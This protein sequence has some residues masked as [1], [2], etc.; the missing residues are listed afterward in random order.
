MG[1]TLE[2]HSCRAFTHSLH[3]VSLGLTAV[4]HTSFQMHPASTVPSAPTH[5]HCD[6]CSP[7]GARRGFGWQQQ[8]PKCAA[9]SPQQQSTLVI[10]TSTP[11]TAGPQQHRESP[12]HPQVYLSPAPEQ[13]LPTVWFI[14]WTCSTASP[15]LVFVSHLHTW[16]IT[17][18][19]SDRV[20]PQLQLG[21]KETHI[22]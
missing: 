16:S 20:S 19:S 4:S 3:R 18:I 15:A 6:C 5:G 14:A 17:G 22:F 21:E 11:A 8:T 13:P 12:E 10:F 7:R 9:H 2:S 1:P